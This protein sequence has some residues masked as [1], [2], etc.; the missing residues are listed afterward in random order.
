MYHE[1]LLKQFQID[2]NCEVKQLNDNLFMTSTSSSDARYWARNKA[3]IVCFN[4]KIFVRTENE[5]LTKEL[6]KM[7]TNI[8]AE[9]F[10]EMGNMYQLNDILKQ[11]H[12]KIE[13]IAPFFIPNKFID[14]ENTDLT[15]QR[16][17]QEDIIHFKQNKQITESFCYSEQDPDQLGFG[18]YVEN[19]LV[20][21][22]GANRN[23]KYTW[24]IGIE[25]LDQKYNKKG[26]ATKLVKTLIATIQK[27]QPDIIPVYSTSLS[28]T[29]SMNVA[30]HAGCRVG[31]SEII[32]SEI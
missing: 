30:I 6:K 3:D 9:W 23:G 21:V 22:C 4:N 16:F 19:H 13:R 29:S 2:F 8:N 17:N 14:S 25:I 20:A 11:Y 24:E 31:W 15:F 12:L 28:H 5:S 7:Y 32:I 27:E 1:R 26:I 18:Y 10:L